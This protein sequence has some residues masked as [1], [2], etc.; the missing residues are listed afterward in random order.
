MLHNISEGEEDKIWELM[1]KL[2]PRPSDTITE[3][4]P[5]DPEGALPLLEATATPAECKQ[6]IIEE[7]IKATGGRLY[8]KKLIPEA[9]APAKA[10]VDDAGFDICTTET[11]TLEPGQRYMTQSGI[12]VQLPRGTYGRLAPRSGLALKKGIDVLAGVIDP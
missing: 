6:E 4:R 3:K 5:S 8:Y 2:D 12:A 7:T 11:F 10:H 1:K 9:V